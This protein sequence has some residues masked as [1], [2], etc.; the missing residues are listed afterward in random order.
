MAEPR[1]TRSATIVAW[2]FVAAQFALIGLMVFAPRDQGFDLGAAGQISGIG[3]M[4]AG[5]A[6]GLWSAVYLGRG[7]T[8]SPLPN[9]SVDLVVAGPYRWARHPMYVAVMLFMA[10][11]AIR[12]GSWMVVAAFGG[13]VALFSVK[14]RW[15][16]AH[17]RDTF[18]GYERYVGKTRRFLPI[19]G[20]T[21]ELSESATTPQP[22]TDE[23]SR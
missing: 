12:S 8:P 20:T 11:V 23:E 2:S 13:L 7:L 1:R 3:L 21:S 22:T 6:L 19:P 5:G 17:L 10:G 16:E 4:V 15:E 14:A 18:P 9:G